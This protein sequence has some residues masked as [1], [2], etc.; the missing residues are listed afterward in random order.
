[1]LIG[2]RRHF[3]L[4]MITTEGLYIDTIRGHET[5]KCFTPIVTVA[6]EFAKSVKPWS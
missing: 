2:E 1:M 5:D 4:N 3:V 6:A